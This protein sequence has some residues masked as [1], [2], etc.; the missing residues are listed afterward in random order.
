MNIKIKNKVYLI[1]KTQRGNNPNEDEEKQLDL[2]L[3]V[4]TK[5]LETVYANAT[6][7]VLFRI[8]GVDFYNEVLKDYGYELRLS[9]EVQELIF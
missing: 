1:T 9:D 3:K 4:A 7:V 6:D 5:T 8:T 2:I